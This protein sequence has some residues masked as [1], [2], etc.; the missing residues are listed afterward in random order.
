MCVAFKGSVRGVTIVGNGVPF[1]R[2]FCSGIWISAN[3]FSSCVDMFVKMN[4]EVESGGIG[5][6][7]SDLD[8]NS[9]QVHQQ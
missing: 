1:E 3:A 5:D 9:D 7:D 6:G 4:S 8:G 2:S